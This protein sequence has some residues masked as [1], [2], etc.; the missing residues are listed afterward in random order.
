[1][2]YFSLE[3]AKLIE[4]EI[5]GACFCQFLVINNT[6]VKKKKKAEIKHQQGNRPNP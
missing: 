4:K 3:T 2:Q 5:L 6:H 1:M